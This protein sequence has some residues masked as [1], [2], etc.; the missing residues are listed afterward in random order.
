[1]EGKMP[2]DLKVFLKKN[3]ISKEITDNLLCKKNN[4]FTYH[5]KKYF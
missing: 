5:L 2:K 1:M 4:F 3:I